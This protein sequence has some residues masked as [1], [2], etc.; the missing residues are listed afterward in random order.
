MCTPSYMYT[1]VVGRLQA[2][3]IHAYRYLVQ[4]E[5]SLTTVGRQRLLPLLESIVR[6]AVHVHATISYTNCHAEPV[7]MI[8]CLFHVSRRLLHIVVTARQRPPQHSGKKPELIR[9]MTKFYL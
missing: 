1:T 2:N 9:Y 8:N 3:L 4:E 7:V 5:V 6:Y